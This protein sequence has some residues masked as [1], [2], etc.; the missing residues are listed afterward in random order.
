MRFQIAHVGDA[1]S[2]M[3]VLGTNTGA[4][5]CSAPSSLG[6]VLLSF[7]VGVVIVLAW[8]ANS[9]EKGGDTYGEADGSTP[10]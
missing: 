10:G 1:A 8:S 6:S 3:G 7:I 4:D 9:M 2:A 5:R